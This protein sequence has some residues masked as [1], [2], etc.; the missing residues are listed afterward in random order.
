MT[1]ESDLRAADEI[2][3]A[4]S[5][6]VDLDGLKAVDPEAYRW[7]LDWFGAIYSAP[8][9]PKRPAEQNPRTAI[10]TKP[11]LQITSMG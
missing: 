3:F 10:S 4:V 2:L 6:Y 9:E 1:A 11:V 8:E 7:L 5:P